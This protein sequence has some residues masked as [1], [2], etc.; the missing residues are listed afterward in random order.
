MVEPNDLYKGVRPSDLRYD[1]V[2]ILAEYIARAQRFADSAT[3]IE[4]S[5]ERLVKESCEAREEGL[6]SL[7][8]LLHQQKSAFQAINAELRATAEHLAGGLTSAILAIHSAGERNLLRA[9][10]TAKRIYENLA[11]RAEGL[12]QS[13]NRLEKGAM[14]AEASR[15][16]ALDE[17]ER[18][19]AFRSELERFERE[20]LAR[21]GE[22]RVELYKGVGL[23]D[24]I[25]FVL[26]PPVP[27][28]RAT[29][30]PHRLPS[31]E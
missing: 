23:W 27:V 28:V 17:I 29:R 10:E 22:A 14:K 20:S 24:R 31:R 1:N 2:H 5:A 8:S 7:Q 3:R 12:N 30:P 6:R 16:Q 18:L 9:D 19:Q 13:A 26:F 11:D 4:A 25:C 21:I 15:G